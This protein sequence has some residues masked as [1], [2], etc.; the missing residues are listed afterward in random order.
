MYWEGAGGHGVNRCLAH[1]TNGRARQGWTRN[2]FVIKSSSDL[3]I[4]K[5]A[6]LEVDLPFL[7]RYLSWFPGD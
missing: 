1:F 3:D 5:D 6:E 2:L 7:K 4:W